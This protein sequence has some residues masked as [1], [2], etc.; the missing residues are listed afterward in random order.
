[1]QEKTFLPCMAENR[2]NFYTFDILHI[3]PKEDETI[4]TL[5]LSETNIFFIEFEISVKDLDT[6]KIFLKSKEFNLMSTSGT[7]EKIKEL[8][9]IARNNC[10]IE[11]L[12]KII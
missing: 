6:E 4:F 10:Y 9:N 1:M 2:F 5:Y 7:K 11:I 12:T 8:K 3:T